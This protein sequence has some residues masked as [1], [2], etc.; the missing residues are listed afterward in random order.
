METI[1]ICGTAMQEMM[2]QSNEGKI[3]V[4]PAIPA[5]WQ[6]ARWPSNCWRAADSLSQP[7]DKRAR[8][9]QFG[10]KSLRGN[11]CR[12]QNPWTG[13][14]V[15]VYEYGRNGPNRSKSKKTRQRHLFCHQTRSRVHILC[16]GNALPRDIPTVFASSPNKAPKVLGVSR[17]LGVGKGFEARGSAD[18]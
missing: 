12:V 2:L 16:Q 18:E 7:K 1:S 8:A 5:E 6:D 9:C 11:L 14:T 15:T 4:F 17:T 3:R 13:Q 10:V